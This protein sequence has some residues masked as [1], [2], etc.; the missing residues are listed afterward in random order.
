MASLDKFQSPKQKLLLYTKLFRMNCCATAIS[1]LTSLLD[2]TESL[3]IHC[4]I[5][6][7]NDFGQL[8]LHF[9]DLLWVD[10]P[11]HRSLYDHQHLPDQ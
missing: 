11:T 2:E 5:E 3:N 8:T 10:Q 9:F 4:T 1:V 6:F 7:F